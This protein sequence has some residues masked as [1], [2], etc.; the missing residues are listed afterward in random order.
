LTF[1]HVKIDKIL[2][3]CNTLVSIIEIREYNHKIN[4]VLIRHVTV[5]MIFLQISNVQKELRKGICPLYCKAKKK[6]ITSNQEIKQAYFVI[7]L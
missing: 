7:T 1:Q 3:N 4:T 2:T 5:I 6:M